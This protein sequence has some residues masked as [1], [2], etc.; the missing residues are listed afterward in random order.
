M[1]TMSEARARFEARFPEPQSKARAYFADYKPEPKDESVASERDKLWR[2][3]QE[4][5]MYGAPPIVR[6]SGVRD[7]KGRL[8]SH[9]LMIGR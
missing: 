5:A 4:N 2:R 1:F 6:Q 8:E 3:S 9:P 7:N